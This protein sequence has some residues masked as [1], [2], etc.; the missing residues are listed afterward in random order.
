MRTGKIARLPANTREELNFA[1]HNGVP[2][3]QLV[4]WLNNQ[5]EVQVV[6]AQLFGGR[7]V[8]KQNVSEWVKGGYR[9]WLSTQ[10]L[11]EKA[12]VY[13]AA[14][15]VGETSPAATLA[16]FDGPV[17]DGAAI[18]SRLAASKPTGE[19]RACRVE[20]GG[21]DGSSQNQSE[22]NLNSIPSSRNQTLSNQNPFISN[23]IQADS[24]Q[25]NKTGLTQPD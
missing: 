9:E 2:A 10:E 5:P 7:P 3:V 13:Q 19:G 14:R 24:N 20:A 4:R 11:I 21:E 22:S 12:L 15:Q 1:L 23:Q 18:A 17:A 8:N 16:T 6:M 25:K